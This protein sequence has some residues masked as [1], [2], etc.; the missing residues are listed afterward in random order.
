MKIRAFLKL[1]DVETAKIKAR[2]CEKAMNG[3]NISIVI[4]LYGLLLRAFG[5][6]ENN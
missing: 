2:P 1:F 5:R 4:N 3:R 6:M